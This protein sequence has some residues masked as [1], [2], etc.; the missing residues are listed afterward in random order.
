[1]RITSSII[2]RG[3]D[4]GCN[5]KQRDL[6]TVLAIIALIMCFMLAGILIA[7]HEDL[8]TEFGKCNCVEITK[9]RGVNFAEQISKI[10]RYEINDY[11]AHEPLNA[12]SAGFRR[13]HRFE[14]VSS[15]DRTPSGIIVSDT[16]VWPDDIASLLASEQI[17]ILKARIKKLIL[18]VVK[19]VVL[20][21]VLVIYGRMVDKTY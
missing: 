21:L 15:A 11:N 9:S 13:R 2:E 10:S 12:Q 1:M 3:V 4:S 8:D 14:R 6:N 17:T 19:V 20:V 7:I 16:V 5:Y 18:F